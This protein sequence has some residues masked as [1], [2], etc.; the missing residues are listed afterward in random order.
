MSEELKTL[1]EVSKAVQETARTSN[2][3]IESFDKAGNFLGEVFGD[4]VKDSVG[5]VSDRLKFFRIER[6][7][8]FKEKT[9][10]K[11]KE[12]GIKVTIPIP[13]K[14]ALPLIEAA[15]VENDDSL[16][17]RWSN[18]LSN[19]IDPSFKGSITRNFVSIL[20]QMNPSDVIILDTLCKEWIS[21]PDE[22]KDTA[23]FDR[24][25]ISTN[26]HI[27]KKECEISL[28]NLIRLGCIKPGVITASSISFGNH[29]LSSY[30]DT[31]LVGVTELGIEFYQSIK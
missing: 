8:S 15:T 9:E 3:A 26:L 24:S 11:L 20:E 31:E 27:D 10:K 12:K 13:P 5:L 25:K 22:N 23:L 28:R 6:F 21:L 18:M 16:Q 4:L 7:F 14:L 19:A 29:G 2:K 30:K 17:Q 1:Q